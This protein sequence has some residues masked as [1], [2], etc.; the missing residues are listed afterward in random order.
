MAETTTPEAAVRLYLLFLDDPQKLVDQS[1]VTTAQAA[2]EEAKDPI[3]RL[4]ALAALEH[5]RQPDTSELEADFVAHAKAYAESESI[6]V[7][8]FREVGVAAD[9][10]RRAGFDVGRRAATGGSS[11]Q[12]RSRAPRTSPESIKGAV[13]RLPK[14][15]TLNDLAD[16]SP[17]GSRQTL[18]KAVDQ[19]IAEG[20]VKKV[21]A[22][23]NYRG[24]GRAPILY[25]QT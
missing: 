4:K 22:V 15:F 23:P 20:K 3:D 13:S 10:L 21:G 12:A 5:A 2:V 8:A 14:Q 18:V 7:A 25:E 19:L 6:P 17:G 1:K 9:I 16:M 11:T 24:R